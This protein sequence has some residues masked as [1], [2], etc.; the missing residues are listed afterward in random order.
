M[1][2]YSQLVAFLSLI[3]LKFSLSALAEFTLVSLPKIIS[4]GA[5]GVTLSGYLDL[6]NSRLTFLFPASFL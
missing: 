6:S 2:V 4:F 1:T 5:S 3:G